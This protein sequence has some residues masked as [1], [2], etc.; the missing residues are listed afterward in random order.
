MNSKTRRLGM[1]GLVAAFAAVGPR[2]VPAQW[3]STLIGVAEYDTEKTQLLLAG[4]TASPSGIG[5]RPMVGLQAY[6]LAFDAGANR[7]NVFTYRPFIGLRDNFT[8]GTLYGT[9]GY[10]FSDRDVSGPVSA[11]VGDQGDGFVLGGGW[12]TWGMPIGWQ[13]LGSYN[14][15]TEALWVRGR[16]TTTLGA[17]PARI[18]AEVAFLQGEDYH[19]IQPGG[20]LQF[21]DSRGRILGLGAGMKFFKGGGDAVYFKVEGVLPLF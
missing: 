16:G 2:E 19:A 9:V 3:S 8:N 10:A 11:T 4:I 17:S 14:F 13:L 20:V 1:A 6:H 15:G 18:G 5:V 21:R 7:V 12:E